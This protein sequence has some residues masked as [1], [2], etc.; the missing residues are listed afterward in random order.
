MPTPTLKP[1]PSEPVATSTKDSRGVGCPSR[2]LFNSR[3]VFRCSRGKSPNSAQAAYSSGAACP[4]DKIK[5]S[6][7]AY[8]GSFGSNRMCPKNSAATKSAAE[9]HDVGWPLPA[10]VVA[11]IESI[12][13]WF[14]MPV[15][16]SSIVIFIRSSSLYA[17]CFQKA[18]LKNNLLRI[19]TLGR[20][21][22]DKG[23]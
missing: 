20:H 16:V 13:N 18:K 6:L 8:R 4:F 23:H 2:S 7:L 15:N 11:A 3:N 14:A 21:S 10:A 22:L 12:R 9:Q 19:V 5:R 17:R 1:C